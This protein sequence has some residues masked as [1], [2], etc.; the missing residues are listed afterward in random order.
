M[1]FAPAAHSRPPFLTAPLAPRGCSAKPAGVSRCHAGKRPLLASRGLSPGALLNIHSAPSSLKAGSCLPRAVAWRLRKGSTACEY[2]RPVSSFQLLDSDSVQARRTGCL[3]QRWRCGQP[4]GGKKYQL[5]TRKPG[6]PWWQENGGQLEPGSYC[7]FLRCV[8]S[9]VSV[10]AP[11]D[12][13]G[14]ATAATH[15]LV[16]VL[17]VDGTW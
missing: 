2:Q 16:R 10:A 8:G 5:E 11:G 7:R 12:S 3:E 15:P 6:K 13:G 14:P 1:Q 4:W 17:E 9:S